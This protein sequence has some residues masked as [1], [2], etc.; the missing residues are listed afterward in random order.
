[1]SLDDEQNHGGGNR[2]SIAAIIV[3]VLIVVGCV[4][5]FNKL[6]QANDELNCVAAGRRNCEQINQ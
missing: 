6:N 2:A 4:W 1:M 5:L 3:V